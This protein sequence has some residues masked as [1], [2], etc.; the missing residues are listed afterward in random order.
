MHPLIHQE[1]PWKT[2]ST[3]QKHPFEKVGQKHIKIY[4]RILKCKYYFNYCSFHLFLCNIYKS[5]KEDNKMVIKDT[6]VICLL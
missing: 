3:L 5:R 2:L 6:E 1:F 4:I